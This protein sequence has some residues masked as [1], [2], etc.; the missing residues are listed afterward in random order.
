MA[1]T[2]APLP[3]QTVLDGNGDPISGAL[4]QT[5]ITGTTTPSP[6]YADADG[7]TEN[8]NPIEADSAGRFVAY[9]APGVTQKWVFKTAAG[10][11]FDTVDPVGAVPASAANLDVIG[12][13]G[14]TLLAGKVVYLSDGSGSK[15][16]GQWFLADADQPYS[17][18][19]PAIGMVPSE[20][21]S[22]ESGTIRLGGRM[23]DLS[24]LTVGTTYYVSATAGGLTATA[25]ANARIVGVA[26]STS[27][28]ILSPNTTPPQNTE[29]T[30]TAGEN[31]AA[32]EAVYVSNGS[33]ALTAGR[34]YKT[35][36]DLEYAS[37]SA[38][39]VGIAP[40]AVASGDAGILRCGG[41][42]TGLTG[43]TAGTSYY[44]AGT[45]GALTA[46]RPTLG[47]LIG[48]ADSTTSLLL[49]TSGGVMPVFASVSRTTTQS[50]GDVSETVCLFDQDDSDAWGLHD[51]GSNT[52]R[53]TMPAGMYGTFRVSAMIYVAGAANLTALFL[54]KNGANQTRLFQR[55]DA[56]GG[57]CSYTVTYLAIGLVPTDYL[58]IAIYQNSGGSVNISD[59]TGQNRNI[60][61]IERVG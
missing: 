21:A 48:I 38:V 35:D 51:T 33:G 30:V 50:I 15:T 10:V 59:T 1:F 60:F 24:G 6:T 36:G 16:A 53:F 26:D 43:L 61:Q 14:E 19:T 45:A 58:E 20:I 56:S 29:L 17:S 39:V 22:G 55:S 28:L 57:A 27:S 31:I 34:M 3:Y 37:V 23:E 2:L 5:Y 7:N 44:A 25:P 46:V 13:A 32:G 18:T 49:N 52:G 9:M 42:V 47:R 4:I 8:D 11:T 12:V 40:N 54:R 41:R